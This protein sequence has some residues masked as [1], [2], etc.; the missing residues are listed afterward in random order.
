MSVMNIMNRNTNRNT[1]PLLKCSGC[2][3]NLGDHC[4]ICQTPSDK[5]LKNKCSAYNNKKLIIAY[6]KMLLR[7]IV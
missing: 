4:A 2:G 6:G 1:K 7:P 3:L 5:W